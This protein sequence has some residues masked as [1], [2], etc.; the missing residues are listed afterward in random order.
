MSRTSGYQFVNQIRKFLLVSVALAAWVTPHF[1]LAAD[2]NDNGVDDAIDISGGASLDCG[3]NGIPDEC[4][5]EGVCISACD[6][7]VLDEDFEAYTVGSD[8]VD[9]FDTQA[10]S[11]SNEDRIGRAHV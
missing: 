3:D 5:P 8:P 2:C 9:W 6:L 11:A 4:E 1:A 10:G 7:V